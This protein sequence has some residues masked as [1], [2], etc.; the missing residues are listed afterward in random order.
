MLA[1]MPRQSSSEAQ[2]PLDF[3]LDPGEA[4]RLPKRTTEH[5]EKGRELLKEAKGLK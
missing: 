2:A 3:A 5:F 1:G 4:E